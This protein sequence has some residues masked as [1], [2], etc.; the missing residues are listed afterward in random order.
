[1][2]FEHRYLDFEP[3]MKGSDYPEYRQREEFDD[4][5]EGDDVEESVGT[6]E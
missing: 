6:V 5:E 4:E 3:R 1:M 2:I